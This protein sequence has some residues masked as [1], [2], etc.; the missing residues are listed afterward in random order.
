[1][2]E[3]RAW[4]WLTMGT[5]AA[6]GIASVWSRDLMQALL[7]ACLALCVVRIIILRMRRR[8]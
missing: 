4:Y 3:V 2:S 5:F 8:G 7:Y 1:M 6:A